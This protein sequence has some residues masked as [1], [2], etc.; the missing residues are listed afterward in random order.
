MRAACVN[1]RSRPLCTQVMIKFSPLPPIE[2]LRTLLELSADSPTGL[3]WRNNGP[4]IRKNR[5]AGWWKEGEWGKIRIASKYYKTHRIVWALHTGEDPGSNLIDHINRRPHD[6]RVENLRLVKH[7]ENRYHSST[8]KNATGY[9]GVTKLQRCA[10]WSAQIKKEGRNYYLG[11]F[12]SPEKA[13]KVYLKAC[14]EL[15]GYIPGTL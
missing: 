8:D 3:K 2:E 4:G 6:N 12:D 13:H 15:Y 7:G 5:V 10:R 1:T 11:C 14:Q 9:R